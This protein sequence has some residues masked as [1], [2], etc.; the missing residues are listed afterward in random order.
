MSRRDNRGRH[1]DR[2]DDRGRHDNRGRYGDRY[3]RGRDRYYDDRYYDDRHRDRY[4]GD[5]DRDRH[6]DRGRNDCLLYTS[7][8]P[9]DR[10]L[11]RMPS[12]A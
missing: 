11:S 1:D 6:D 2:Y 5:R 12:S 8:S 9:R 10:S 7:P 4:Y 3:D